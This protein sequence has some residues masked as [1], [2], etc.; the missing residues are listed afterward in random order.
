MHG[1]LDRRRSQ[2]VIE[3]QEDG[4]W[5]DECDWC[6]TDVINPTGPAQMSTVTAQAAPGHQVAKWT[7]CIECYMR[8][9]KLAAD[10]NWETKADD[11]RS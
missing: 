10:I 9:L 3:P 6:L 1:L 11:R 7:I 5:H 2:L 4:C 8:L